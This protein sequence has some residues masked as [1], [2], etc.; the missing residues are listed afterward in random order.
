MSTNKDKDPKVRGTLAPIADT[1]R[2]LTEALTGVAGSDRKDL[3]LSIGYLLQRLRGRTFLQAFNDEWERLRA[4][5]RIK[6]DYPQTEQCQACLQE[7]LD[8]LDRDSPDKI[9]FDFIKRIFLAAAT[10]TQSDRNSVLPQQLM[11]LARRL[12]AGEILVLSGTFELSK[13]ER[14]AKA[15]GATTWLST[16]AKQSGLQH[17]SLVE[18]HE[19]ALIEKKLLT[20]RRYGD[21]SGVSLGDHYRLTSLGLSLCEFVSTY[22][23]MGDS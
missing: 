5:G 8:C 1:L 17:P 23:P 10:E 6:D 13:S 14:D 3:F 9:R 18:L 15:Q 19:G 20:G 16:V 11:G 4:K 22:D 2:A 21:G 7:I 12:S